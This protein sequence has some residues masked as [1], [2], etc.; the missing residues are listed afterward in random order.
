MLKNIDWNALRRLRSAPTFSPTDCPN[1]ITYRDY[2]QYR[3]YA[4][5]LT[6]LLLATG[7]GPLFVGK[8]MAT[9]LGDSPGETWMVVRYPSHRGMLR[10]IFNPYYLLVANRFRA[11]G[12]ARIE[13][14]FTQPRSNDRALAKQPMVLGV[15]VETDD[16]SG[17]FEQLRQYAVSSGLRVVYESEHR[18]NLDFI[19]RPRRAD[20]VPLTYPTTAALAGDNTAALEQF[21]G[22]AD[23]KELLDAQRR[24]CVQLYE[25]AGKFEL[26]R[27]GRAG[28]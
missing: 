3:W 10:M 4:R 11:K 15:H 25:G 16:A 17:F 9:L 18:L 8:R 20:P 14:A 2:E 21:A 6:P 7:G 22:R 24:A 26:L 28:N 1:F 19:R 5:V 23:V 13:L 12:T 27:F